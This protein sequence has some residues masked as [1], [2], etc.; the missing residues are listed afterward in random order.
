MTLSGAIPLWMTI[1]SWSIL[2]AYA[3]KSRTIPP[4][5]A[6]SRLCGGWGIVLWCR[7]AG[8]SAVLNVLIPA[9][10]PSG[11]PSHHKNSRSLEAAGIFMTLFGAVP[12]DFC[13][14]IRGTF[15]RHCPAEAAGKQIRAGSS[16]HAQLTTPPSPGVFLCRADS[17]HALQG[18]PRIHAFQLL[19]NFDRDLQLHQN[20]IVAVIKN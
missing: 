14:A 20:G 19:C 11:V 4:S 8:C 18:T 17:I 2:T 15:M 13:R 1:A 10:R 16:P 9:G 7:E 5:P 12:C 6:I 3:K